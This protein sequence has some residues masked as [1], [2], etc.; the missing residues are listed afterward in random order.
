MLWSMSTRVMETTP[1]HEHD[2]VEWV[3]CRSGSGRL[4]T[5]SQNVDLRPGRTLV[6]TAG[7][8]HRFTFNAG[9]YADL[10]FLCLNNQD[11]ATYLS[12]AQVVLLERMRTAPVSYADHEKNLLQVETLTD[13]IEDGFDISDARD[14]AVAWGVVGMLLALHVKDG[15]GLDD[16]SWHRYRQKIQDIKDWIDTRLD[17]CITLD[18]IGEKFGLSRS[19]VTREFRRHTGKS[20]IDY[21]NGRRIEKAATLLAS[22]Q[23]S[24]TQ[25]AF[26]S[27]FFNLSH[28]HR[29]FKSTY[30]LTPVA[31]RRQIL[32][33]LERQSHELAI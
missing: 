1:W 33:T 12:P 16:Y 3:F 24:V 31:F 30:G 15:N 7:S 11:T 4:E 23:E 29:Q 32:G 19:V 8:R 22:G 28:F 26:K 20:V 9:E 14:L 5:E 27:G 2:I 17:N 18:A 6:I 21:C 25:A 10:K 13:L